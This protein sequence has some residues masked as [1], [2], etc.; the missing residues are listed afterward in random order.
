[1]FLVSPGCGDFWFFLST[2]LSSLSRARIH[3]DSASP[4]VCHSF[5]IQRIYGSGDIKRGEKL[6]MVGRS[7]VSSTLSGLGWSGTNQ[8]R[9]AKTSVQ[10]QSLMEGF[11]SSVSQTFKP[12]LEA[13]WGKISGT[14]YVPRMTAVYVHGQSKDI[15]KVSI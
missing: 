2:R 5:A 10:V 9:W 11:H 3:D 15:C 6:S 12:P 13:P 1:M 7:T 8:L 4:M 14:T